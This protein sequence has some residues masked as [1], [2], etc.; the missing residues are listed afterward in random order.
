MKRPH[1]SG[2]GEIRVMTYAVSGEPP[3]DRRQLARS[4]PKGL[5][6]AFAEYESF[7]DVIHPATLIP[8]IGS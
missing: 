8:R 5:D 1:R 4:R 6:C 2:L 7:G 3:S